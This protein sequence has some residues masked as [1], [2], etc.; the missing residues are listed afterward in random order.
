MTRLVSTSVSGKILC[1][2]SRAWSLDEFPIPQMKVNKKVHITIVII[3]Q[4]NIYFI[5]WSMSPFSVIF[6]QSDLI[7]LHSLSQSKLKFDWDSI[8]YQGRHKRPHALPCTLPF[9]SISFL[10]QPVIHLTHP[11]SLKNDL[12]PA[13]CYSCDLLMPHLVMW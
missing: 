6:T 13:L 2:R 10:F 9:G 8:S 4:Q 11:L 5:S 1:A 7:L 12:A 3:T